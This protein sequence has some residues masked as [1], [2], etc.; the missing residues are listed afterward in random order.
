MSESMRIDLIDPNPWQPRTSV[1]EAGIAEL[2]L[3]IARDGL[4]Q[5]PVA[6][7]KPADAPGNGVF[8][9]VLGHRRLAAYRLLANVQAG[10]HASVSNGNDPALIQAVT[11]ALENGLDFG[12]MPI[13]VLPQTDRQMFES[14]IAENIQRKDLNPVELAAAMKRYMIEFKA[15]SDVCG[16]FFGVSGATVRGNV[17]LMDL[18]EEARKAMADGTIT[19][20]AARQLLTL[21]K[22]LPEKMA[23]ALKRIVKGRE[24]AEGVVDH[25]FS[26][27]GVRV[28]E[29]R[30]SRNDKLAGDGLWELA[31]K[32]FPVQ[33]L[34]ELADDITENREHLLNPPA[35]T[36]CDLFVILKGDRFCGLK[37][38]FLRKETAWKQYKL[39]KASAKLK[40]PIYDRNSDG[41]AYLLLDFSYGSH[42][43]AYK[44]RHADLRIGPSSLFSGYTYQ[45]TDDFDGSLRVI[46]VGGSVERLRVA[47]SRKMGK[48]SEKEKAEARAMKA[49][50]RYRKELMWDYT[51]V[52]KDLFAG[53]PMSTLKYICG[54][55]YSSVLDCIP[56]EFTLPPTATEE[57]KLE[58]QRRF[59]V[60]KLILAVSTHFSRC[61]LENNL[62]GFQK[63]T[64]VNA[65]QELVERARLWD[66]EINGL[67]GVSAETNGDE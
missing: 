16:Q 44:S 10:I 38:C 12:E 53:V 56:D 25:I 65:P 13:D 35:C 45:H 33:H 52:A 64:G 9:L 19:V 54:W 26:Y 63:M 58:F 29:M 23:E 41:D 32:K 6:R 20:G 3:S 11:A 5:I 40:I 7:Q 61:S 4:K 22:L 21:Q 30:W 37:P 2:A 27:S 46:V 17:R 67:A 47:G 36:A 18:P 15:T 57:E 43:K 49:Y 48:K 55:H 34:P 59:L 42:E 51:G 62:K 8:Q 50:R 60:W 14:A 39:E 31:M 24:E 66:A 1:D 28:M